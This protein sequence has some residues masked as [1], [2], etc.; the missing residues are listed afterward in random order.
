MFDVTGTNGLPGVLIQAVADSLVAGS[1]NTDDSG[2]FVISGLASNVYTVIPSLACYVFGPSNRVASIGLTNAFGLIFF[3]TN[4]LHTVSGTILN[5]PAGVTVTVSGTNGTNV[6]TSG[7]G[8]YE[9][10]GLCPGFYYVVPSL[11]GYQFQPPAYSVLLPPDATA[12]NFTAL[13]V[14]GISGRITQGTN[15]PPLSG[16]TLAISGPMATNV[17]TAADGSYV[18]GGLPAGTYAVTPAS[19]PSCF[20]FNAT[21]RT[22]TLGP[23]DSTGTDFVA[24]QDAY[25]ISGHLNH[26]AAGLSGLSVSVGGT[27]LTTTDATGLYVFSNLCAGAYTVTPSGGCYLFSPPFSTAT[28]GL[29]NAVGLDFNLTNDLHTI[30]GS[31]SNSPA[32]VV[33]VVLGTNGTQSVNSSGGAY[34]VSNLCAGFYAVVPSRPG[35][36]FQPPTNSILVPP[37]AGAVN[38]TAI[39]VFGIS[40]KV[41]QGTNGPGLSGIR[42]AVSGSATTNV[43]TAADGT[44]LVYPLQAGSYRVTPTAP[45]CSHFNLPSQSV[46]LGPT[47][48]A[49]MNFVLLPDAYTISGHLTNGTSGVSGISVS[50]GGTNVVVTDPNGRYVFSNLCAGSYTVTPSA[51]CYV[52]SPTSRSVVAG[53][54]DANGVDFGASALVYTVSGRI[55]D[56]SLGVSN[57][58]VQAGNLTATTDAGGNYVLSGLC[59]GNYNVT[60][61]QNCRIF[62]P[63]SIPVTLGPN[64]AG[65]NFVSFS[66]NLS[67]IRGQITDGVNG[68]SNALVSAT[69][70]GTAITDATG[71]YAFSDLCPGTY[72]VTPSVNGY[73]LSPQSLTITLGSAQ[74]A[75]G[76]NFVAAPAPYHISGRLAGM[77]AGPT[78]RISIAGATSTNILFTSTGAYGI[79]NLCP[80]TYLVTPSN[81]CYQF[82]PLS[83]TTTVG[84]SDDGLD[85]AVSG[86]GE[87]SIRGQVT[88]NAVGLSNVTVIA[89]GQTNLTDVNGNYAFPGLCP[90][91]YAVTA[92]APNYQFNPPTNYVT[93]STADSNGVNFVA[94]PSASLCGRVVE[95]TSGLPGVR[96]SAGTN[97]SFTGVGGYYTN[98]SLPEGTNVLVVV[99]SLAGYGFVPSAQSLVLSSNTNLPDFMAF[100]SLVLAQATNG[101][102]QLTFTPAFTCQV[103]ASTDFSHW[104]AVFSTNNLSTNTLL[105]QFTDTDAANL[106]TRFYRLGQTFAGQPALTNWTA[107]NHI[108]SLGCG[109][110]PVLACRIDA[111]TNLISWVTVFSTN[112]P[113]ATPFQFQYLETSNSPVRFYRL[114]QTPGL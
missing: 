85:F 11:A 112:L 60:P 4:D 80:G 87:F 91:L 69:G 8:T 79:S 89:S 29:A 94:I 88:Y 75:N 68:L 102:V 103:Q 27:N 64:V 16:I 52:I 43:T 106:T 72:A 113:A 105:L 42:L 57:V 77:P 49:G 18:V 44:F 25:T 41:S 21:S 24:L 34:A 38:F 54:T 12:V 95:G 63:A 86:G 48:A 23:G 100:P 58:T 3:A 110:A 28:V 46:T 13:P 32:N 109:A 22:V 98:L 73:C 31:I 90:G 53:P 47:N 78:V 65:V 66:D 33:V 6:V 19:P 111:S 61:S 35:Y 84:P 59:P 1:T 17:T 2:S 99:P 92:S 76:V 83:W 37:D 71:N 20:H 82:Y 74:T 9:V 108:V 107:T 70:A 81:A 114:S 10:S 45:G 15:G 26:G 104:E 67:R 5:G 7:P 14:F 55:T 62:N 30:S 36:I 97:I 101:A 96:I 56:S 51:T 40:G 93:L 50:A 39:Q